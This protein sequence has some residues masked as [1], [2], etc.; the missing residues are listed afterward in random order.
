MTESSNKLYC[1]YI[2][3]SRR[4][5]T[6]YIGMTSELKKRV[7]EHKNHWVEGFTKKYEVD[8]LVHY[9]TFDSP[10]AAIAREKKLKNWNRD[11][12]IHLIERYNPAWND[13]YE[14]L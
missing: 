9:E 10:Q 11:W 6:L 2:L 13:L 1:V 3:A 4:N 8:R 12:K 5:G 14:D 7:W